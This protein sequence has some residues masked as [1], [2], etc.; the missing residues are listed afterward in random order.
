MKKIKSFW[1]WLSCDRR[2][3]IGVVIILMIIA[4]GG[5]RSVAGKTGNKMQY[6]TSTVQKGTI[7]STVSASGTALTTSIL[8]INTN[9]SGFV[10]K[11]YV[12]DGDKVIAGQKIAEI[13][14]DQT[15]LEKN[16]SSYASYINA[17]NGVNSANNSYRSAQA[18][19]EKVLDDVKGHDSDET[20]TQ[21]E[22]RTKAEVTRDNAYDGLRSAQASLSSASLS[23]RASSPTIITPFSGIVD[24]VALVEGMVLENTSS[25]TTST[26]NGVRV[27]V[28]KNNSNPIV[29]VTL[30]EIDVLKVKVGQKA[31]VIF[32]SLTDKTFTGVVATVDRV[33]TVASNVTSY[34]V[35]IKLDSGSDLILPNMAATANI[36]LETKTDVLIVPASSI[37]T[38]NGQVVVKTLK[39][40]V[41]VDVPV[42][43]G[44]SSDLDIEIV[45]GITEGEKV[46]TGTTTT[47]ASS[48]TQTRSVF[49][50]GGFGGGAT[51][52]GR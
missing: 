24:G 14:L 6:Q 42:T 48:G 31:T 15:G 37:T 7:V 20:L 40:G 4:V 2:R 8:S 22:S 9:A 18:S 52:I 30:S 28:V 3:L 17:L 51:R 19:A 45:S 11:V 27:A 26:S 21:K 13:T 16:A 47:P 32:D 38:Q 33:G 1:K 39:N 35:N 12:K 44:I 36:I 25:S 41:E 10:K 46:I 5:W 49:S 23:Y 43:T 50:T 29:S 34:K